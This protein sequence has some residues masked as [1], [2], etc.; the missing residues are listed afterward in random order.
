MKLLKASVIIMGVLIL[1]GLTVIVVVIINRYGGDQATG[2][3]PAR[4]TSAIAAP[5]ERGFGERAIAIPKGAETVETRLDGNRMVVRLRL[6]DGAT[7]L[8]FLD[9]ITGERLGLVRLDPR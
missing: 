2:N 6:A 4:P 9:S 1:V 5:V 7:A 3:S 8:L